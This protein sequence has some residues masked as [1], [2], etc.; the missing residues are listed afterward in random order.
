V[1]V[2]ADQGRDHWAR[3]QP[4][5]IRLR[6][7]ARGEAGMSLPLQIA[8]EVAD[9]TGA[10]LAEAQAADHAARAAADVNRGGPAAGTFLQVRLDRLAAAANDTIAAARDDDFA[11]MR[12][13]LRRFDAL[14]T[15]MRAVQDAV[16]GPRPARRPV[17]RR[18]A[19]P[20][21]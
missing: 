17:Q 11:G 8:A 19:R 14:T 18:L 9:A 10:I 3:C 7:L 5:L 2:A 6:M 12:R 15:A 16:Y 4:H 13:H 1:S 20:V 21:S